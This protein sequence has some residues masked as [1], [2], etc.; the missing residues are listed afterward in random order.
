LLTQAAADRWAGRS[1]PGAVVVADPGEIPRMP[2]GALAVPVTA[3]AREHT[4]KPIAAGMVALGCVA[5]LSDAVRLPALARAIAANMPKSLVDANVA[6]CA[7]GIA[8]TLAARKELS[9][10]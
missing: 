5:A 7:A 1:K 4:G 9:H 10:V 3:L 6:A 2:A 8:A